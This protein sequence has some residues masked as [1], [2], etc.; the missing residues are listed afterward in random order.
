LYIRLRLEDTPEF[1]ALERAGQV[2]QAPLRE[3]IT[4]NWREMLQVGG[5]AILQNVGFYLVLTYVQTYIIQLG[6]PRSS[7]TL[8]TALTILVTMALLPLLGAFSDR[9]GRKPLLIASSV[10]FAALSYPLF[11]FMSQ[12]GLPSVV[13]GHVALGILLA[14]FISVN[15]TVLVELLPTRV[16][17]GGFSIGYNISVAIFT[18]PA[19]ALSTYLISLTGNQAAPA[20]YIIF[21]AAL[22]LVTLLTIRETAGT[23]LRHTQVQP[24]EA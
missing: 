22:T 15:M 4:Q 21:A 24:R 14:L 17:V 18:G 13:L 7:A 23:P 9:R 1:R 19:A 6:Y 10:G 11:L 20:F 8:S 12:G 3:T 5:I 16:R 2:A